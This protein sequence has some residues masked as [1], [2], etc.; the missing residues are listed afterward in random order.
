ATG[1][2]GAYRTT[3]A[4]GAIGGVVLYPLQKESPRIFGTSNGYWRYGTTVDIY[5]FAL[6][7]LLGNNDALGAG[8]AGLTNLSGGINYKPTPRLRLTGSFNRVDTETLN[9]QAGAFL[10]QPQGTGVVS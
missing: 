10:S 9:I 3:A 4:Y 2:G 5:H 8:H 6:I 1:F 7:D